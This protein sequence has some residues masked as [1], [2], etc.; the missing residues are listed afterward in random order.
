M[1]YDGSA[2]ML[3]VSIFSFEWIEWRGKNETPRERWVTNHFRFQIKY[4]IKI[5]WNCRVSGLFGRISMA[6]TFESDEQ[7]QPTFPQINCIEHLLN[8][9][10]FCHFCDS[11][12]RVQTTGSFP[13]VS[14]NLFDIFIEHSNAIMTL[15]FTL[16]LIYNTWNTK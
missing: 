15:T 12:Y 16:K 5:E 9:I 14:L 7:I 1:L 6:L 11:F 8:L 3:I 10:R 2:Q 4:L 13:V